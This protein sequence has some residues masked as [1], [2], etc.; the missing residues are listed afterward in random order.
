MPAPEVLSALS[1]GL[2]VLGGLFG[3]IGA[4][5]LHRL[6]DFFSRTHASGMVDTFSAPMILI[7]LLLQAQQPLVAV[8]LALIL[9]FLFFTSPTASHALARAAFFHGLRP[10]LKDQDFDETLRHGDLGA[11]P[12]AA[13]EVE[14]S[15]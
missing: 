2:L 9:V 4:V 7:G 10:V 14:P 1:W 3:L 5:G 11:A 15:R 6:P 13:G 8:K 12:A